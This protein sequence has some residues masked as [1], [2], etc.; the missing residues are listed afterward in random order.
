MGFS[1]L[2]NVVVFAQLHLAKGS[3]YCYI[4][5]DHDKYPNSNP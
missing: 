3:S 4:F 5:T 2:W 1:R